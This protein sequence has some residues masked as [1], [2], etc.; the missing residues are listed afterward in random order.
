[1]AAFWV[2]APCSLRERRCQ[3]RHIYVRT[4]I[5]TYTSAFSVILQTYPED[6]DRASLPSVVIWQ[7]WSPEEILH[8][9]RSLPTFQ[10]YL[11]LPSPGSS[12]PPREPKIV[13]VKS[14]QQMIWQWEYVLQVQYICIRSTLFTV[15]HA[16][17]VLKSFTENKTLVLQIKICKSD[18]CYV[19]NCPCS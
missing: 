10:R 19:H 12:P 4:Y 7:G 16:W 13:C 1:M 5:H 2:V 11:L 14:W 3:Y 18:A 15:L 6:G 9:G 17:L 8:H